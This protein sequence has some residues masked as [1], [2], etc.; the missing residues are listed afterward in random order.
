MSAKG[1][2]EAREGEKGKEERRKG[3][4]V[5]NNKGGEMEGGGRGIRRRGCENKR[6]I[7]CRKA[8]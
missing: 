5:S 1:G 2:K 8:D 3:P 4:S 7:P 6:A